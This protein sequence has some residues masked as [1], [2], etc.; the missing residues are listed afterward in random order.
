MTEYVDNETGEVMAIQPVRNAIEQIERSQLD[1]QMTRAAQRPRSIK[2]FENRAIQYATHNEEIA[3]SCFYALK[4]GGKFIEGPSVRLAEIMLSAWGNA[5]CGARII[6]EDDK[7]VVAQGVAVDLETNTSISV[8]V[9]RR[10]TDK[11]GNK[12]KD[13]MIIVTKNAACAIAYRN[14]ALKMIPG[15][16]A[17]KV[18]DQA[19]RV[20]MGEGKPLSERR[21]RALRAFGEYDVTEKQILA[22]LDCTSI[23]EVDDEDLATLIGLYNALKS[24]ETTVEESFPHA[25]LDEKTKQ[26]EAKMAQA[27]DASTANTEQKADEKQSE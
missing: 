4:R 1:V 8:E 17:A 27:K 22:T 3:Q 12:Y 24:G 14:A 5:K 19:R 10:I 9:T 25:S 6:S 7:V 11:H 18:M 15:A 16:F 13:D 21:Q 20:A 23:D 26:A 2:R